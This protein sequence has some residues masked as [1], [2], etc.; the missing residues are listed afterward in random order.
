M[1]GR[2]TA[3]K[4]VFLLTC[5]PVG[6]CQDAITLNLKIWAYKDVVDTTGNLTVLFVVVEGAVLGKSK[7][8]VLIAVQKPATMGYCL[9]GGITL[10]G[11]EVATQNYS[12]IPA[13]QTLNPR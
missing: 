12:A 4:A 7:A 9:I 1:V 13:R 8:A 5:R 10:C 11:V 3:V 2:Q 6:V